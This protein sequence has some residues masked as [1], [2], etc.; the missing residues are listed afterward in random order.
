MPKV[1]R[2][3]YRT[4]Y[5]RRR[6]QATIA[7]HVNLSIVL[8]ASLAIAIGLISIIMSMSHTKSDTSGPYNLAG[9][10]S[11]NA[12]FI[13]QVLEHY[14]S[15]AKGKGQVLYDDGVKYGID[16][17]YAL[18]FFMQ[19]SRMG[20]QGVASVT[21][22]LGNIRATTGYA[23]YHGYRQYANWEEGFEDWYKLISQQYIRDWGLHTVDQIIPV[24]A[25][26]EDN[27]NEQQYISA[28]KYMVDRWR[29]G[30]IQIS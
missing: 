23:N 20:T 2:R 18:A 4:S 19:E 16:P 27:N 26:N 22:S 21:H 25:P 14:D 17:A 8:L 1:R 9:A 3:T 12:N 6:P 29:S 15:P 30:D 28:I 24:Y 11:I 7:S 10:P 13:D 5:R